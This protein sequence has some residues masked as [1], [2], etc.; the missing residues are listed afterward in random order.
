M[1]EGSKSFIAIATESTE[2]VSP[3]TLTKVRNT[4]GSGLANDRTVINSE[5]LRD[6]GQVIVS[7][8]GNNAPSLEIPIEF[9]FGEDLGDRNFENLLAAVMGDSKDADSS[10]NWKNLLSPELV[11]GSIVF[12]GTA[13]TVTLTG[14]DDNW[15]TLG[16]IAGNKVQFVAGGTADASNDAVIMTVGSISSDGSILNISSTNVVDVASQTLTDLK[17]YTMKKG[18]LNLGDFA[19]DSSV[20]TITLSNSPDVTFTELGIKE[21]DSVT[22]TGTDIGTMSGVEVRVASV[23][24]TGLI[25]TTESGDVTSTV[26]TVALSTTGDNVLTTTTEFIST[27][28]DEGTFT[29]AQEFIDNND[30]TG[31]YHSVTG[32]KVGTASM[33]IQP[34]SIITG[35]FGLSG[36]YY[37][38]FTAGNILNS[39]ITN[40][41]GTTTTVTAINE[42]N[43]ND[44]LD[45]FIGTINIYNTTLASSITSKFTGFDF[46]IDR[47]PN[48]RYALYDQNPT[49]I[50][51]GRANVSGTISSYF[52]KLELAQA[53]NNENEIE[54]RIR[55]IDSSYNSYLFGFPK[56]KFTSDSRDITENDVNQTI[57]FVALG[58]VETAYKTMYVYRQPV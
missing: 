20:D 10:A 6:D 18:I 16:V 30:N 55:M 3:D 23:D 35:T 29:V 46:T 15:F 27:G 13:D 34:D 25:I 39:D 36:Q 38:G 19:T 40:G 1:A 53:Y 49:S 37:N 54:V 33:S 51:I 52:D 56:I 21:G 8:L 32:C 43:T 17:Y 12:N 45:S 2:R 11:T 9:S 4:G 22:F 47:S 31:A 24:A 58:D 44:V 41:N 48:V 14:S 28:V 57:N 7:R 42:S 50:G 26:S 5:E